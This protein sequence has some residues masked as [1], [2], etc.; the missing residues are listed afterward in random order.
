MEQMM[1][2]AMTARKEEA[3][4]DRK[5]ER[6]KVRKDFGGGLKKGFLSGSESKGKA[7]G[8][9]KAG[10]TSRKNEATSQATVVTSTKKD[11]PIITGR[12]DPNSSAS[13]HSGLEFDLSTGGSAVADEGLILPEVQEA[14]KSNAGNPLGGE[15]GNTTS[16]LTPELLTKI[17][18]KPRLAAMLGD[19]QFARA[20]ALLATAPEEAANLFGRSTETRETFSELMGLLGDHFNGLDNDMKREEIERRKAAEGPLMQEA[21]RRHAKVPR[22]PPSREEEV[23]VQQILGQAELRELLLDPEMQ[24][25]LHKC[26]EPGKLRRYMDD[27]VVGPKI[28]KLAKAGLVSFQG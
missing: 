15:E 7:K 9:K 4:K 26:G 19:P 2:E 8:K 16:W 24:R 5:H 10:H 14:M 12:K 6:Q 23:E 1:E 18:A 22:E 11:M 3:K 13:S 28:Q 21:L 17:S 27:P 25:V 20:M